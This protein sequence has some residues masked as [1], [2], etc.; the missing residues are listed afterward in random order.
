MAASRLAGWAND[1]GWTQTY[2]DRTDGVGTDL[3]SAYDEAFTA[4]PL[5]PRDSVATPDPSYSIDLDSATGTARL[6]LSVPTTAAAVQPDPLPVPSA[7]GLDRGM[8]GPTPRGFPAA[9]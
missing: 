3:T 8:T 5:A 2:V 4:L 1:A 9:G 6:T 7:A